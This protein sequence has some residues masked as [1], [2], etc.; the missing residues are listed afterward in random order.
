VK[1]RSNYECITDNYGY[2]EPSDDRLPFCEKR[3]QERNLPDTR[4]EYVFTCNAGKNQMC[5]KY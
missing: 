3:N 1:G 2:C 5:V 4:C